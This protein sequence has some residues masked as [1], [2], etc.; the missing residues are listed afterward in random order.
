MSEA[1]HYMEYKLYLDKIRFVSLTTYEQWMFI[2][3]K[4][5]QNMDHEKEMNVVMKEK[6]E[7]MLG[8]LHWGEDSYSW[9][10]NTMA[11][12]A[13]AFRVL[14]NE[15]KYKE[16]LNSIIQFFLERRSGGRWRN[17]VESA[18]TLETILPTILK[19]KSDFNTN[20][21]LSI[22][23]VSTEK[24][25]YAQTVSNDGKPIS[26]SKSGGGLMYFTAWQKIFNS[27]PDPVSDKFKI[28]TWFE[29]NGSTETFIKAGEKITM[30]IKIEVLKDAD[31][32]QIEIPIPAGC[33]YAGKRQDEWGM[34]KE[35]YK[36]KLVIFAEKMTKGAYSF[37]I[38][39][40]PRY[41]GTYHLNPAKAELMYFP[42]FYGRNEMKDVE[43][44]K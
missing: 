17:T 42:V 30:R 43:I 41:A 8:G 12:T 23:G 35:F 9:E 1:G 4:Q 31:Y 20:A 40:E 18:V 32:V 36:N 34:H 38:E 27:D 3:I 39:L 14:E 16:M 11:T 6:I 5:Q 22:N 10:N 25:P 15:E 7:T 28:N 29:K 13:L 19:T 24:F 33:T 44:R 2:K 21:R 26:I 37:E